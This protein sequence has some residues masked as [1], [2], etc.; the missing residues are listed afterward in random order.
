MLAQLPDG[1]VHEDSHPGRQDPDDLK[2]ETTT[3]A[4]H[5]TDRRVR[6]ARGLPFAAAQDRPG[7][8]LPPIGELIRR[9]GDVEK[10]R[11]D[12]ACAVNSCAAAIA[13]R[14]ASGSDQTS[15]RRCENSRDELVRSILSPSACHQARLPVRSWWG[16][17]TAA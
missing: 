16:L 1:G 15:R 17:P 8:P 10:G 13:F 5:G 7:Q 3:L 14:G 9:D 11:T 6:P 2:N 4:S 12:N